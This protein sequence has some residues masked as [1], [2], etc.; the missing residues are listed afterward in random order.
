MPKEIH[1]PRT[2]PVLSP[3]P[4]ESQAL[5]CPRNRGNSKLVAW[6][7]NAKPGRWTDADEAEAIE[8]GSRDIEAGLASLR[9]L[10]AEKADLAWAQ[11]AW[12]RKAG[13]R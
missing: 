12:Y 3:N 13:A 5:T 1:P 4:L 10:K 9:A 11:S 8:V 7:R 2:T 6:L